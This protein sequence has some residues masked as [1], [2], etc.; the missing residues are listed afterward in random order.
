[1]IIS[2]YACLATPI[3]SIDLEVL[4]FSNGC[5]SYTIRSANKLGYEHLWSNE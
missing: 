4:Q 1:M 3:K 5:K 2:H